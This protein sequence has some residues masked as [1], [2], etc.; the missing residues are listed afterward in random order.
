MLDIML[1]NA[2]EKMSV[3]EKL[4]TMEVLWDDLCKRAEAIPSPSWHAEVLSQR[5]DAVDRG[6]ETPEDWEVAKNRIR[7]S[8]R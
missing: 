6:D 2:F 8:L 5:A 3:E 4:L 1:N 7:Q